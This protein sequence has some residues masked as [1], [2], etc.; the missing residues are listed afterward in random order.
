MT[1]VEFIDDAIVLTNDHFLDESLY[2]KIVDPIRRIHTSGIPLEKVFNPLVEV[3]KMSAIL[4]GLK[5]DYPEFDIAGTI[6][7]LIKLSSVINDA[8]S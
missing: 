6:D 3:M 7:R 8:A 5:V 1:I 4:K 2:P